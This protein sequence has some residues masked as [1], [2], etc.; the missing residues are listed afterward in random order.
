[1][2]NMHNGYRGLSIFLGLNIDR[3][4][5]AVAIGTAMLLAAW[6]QSL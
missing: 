5:S 6:I 4:L 1:M 3:V 2:R